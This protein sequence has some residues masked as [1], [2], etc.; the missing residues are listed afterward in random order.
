MLGEGANERRIPVSK[1]VDAREA[2]NPPDHRVAC[3]VISGLPLCLFV[4][5]NLPLER[6]S[7]NRIKVKKSKGS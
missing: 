3:L 7:K 1:K 6:P 4:G 5:H 2:M